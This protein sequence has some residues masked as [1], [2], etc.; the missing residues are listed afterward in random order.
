MTRAGTRR[1]I[2]AVVL[3]GGAALA[4]A[5]CGSDGDIGSLGDPSA[6]APAATVSADPAKAPSLVLPADEFPAGFQVQD[7]PR[8]QM[9]EIT[10]QVLS[11]TKGATIKPASCAQLTLL[12]D[13]FDVSQV[14]LA[15]ASKGTTSLAT[16]VSVP[17]ADMAASRAAVTGDCSKL[18][19]SFTTGPAA[20]A[21]ATV[22]QKLVDAPK[23][24]AQ[25]S[26]VVVQKTAATVN[27]QTVRSESRMGIAMVNGYQ[28]TAQYMSPDGSPIDTGVFDEFFVEAI[29]HVADETA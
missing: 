17:Q 18:S 9:Q 25:E 3:T 10:D 6:Q 12:P 15:V 5:G 24:K 16:A 19:M 2:G 22:D 27:G 7:I 28:V 20:G 4:L 8:S 23:S 29:D 11:A 1:R 26:M 14:G 21:T 13:E